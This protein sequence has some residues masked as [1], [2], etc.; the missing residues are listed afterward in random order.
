MI[1]IKLFAFALF[2]YFG[3]KSPAR[4]SHRILGTSFLFSP[5]TIKSFCC[6]DHPSGWWFGVCRSVINLLHS[7]WFKSSELCIHAIFGLLASLACFKTAQ[8]TLNH[9]IRCVSFLPTAM[10]SRSPSSQGSL[11]H[12]NGIYRTFGIRGLFQGGTSVLLRDVPG[13]VT[14]FTSYEILLDLGSHGSRDNVGPLATIIAGGLAGM[15]SW[16]S[17][18]PLDVV[19]SRM[20]ADGSGGKLK[21]SGMT[22]CILKTYSTG[23]VRSFFRGIG[24]TLLRA[25]PTNAVIFP[26][27]TFVS[28]AFSRSSSDTL[29]AETKASYS[30]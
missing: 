22:D 2:A 18:F 23:G 21:Y 13:F 20:Q 16:A 7:L 30:V 19:K 24:P 14:Y 6:V 10:R 26:I 27:Y 15:I 8:I 5:I 1:G 28:R 11:G 25:F 4:H 29:S 9:L 17:T 3:L 12:F